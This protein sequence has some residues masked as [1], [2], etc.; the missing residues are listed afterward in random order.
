MWINSQLP[1]LIQEYCRRENAHI[2][3][4]GCG[5]GEYSAVFHEMGIKGSYLGIDIVRHQN[6]SGLKMANCLRVEHKVFDAE[7][8]GGIGREFDFICA[9]TSFEHFKDDEAVLK[10]AYRVLKNE[11]RMLV[12]VPSHYSILNY[13]KHGWRQYSK[14]DIIEVSARAGFRTEKD[15]EICGFA[16][17]LFHLTWYWIFKILK[18]CFKGIVVI[19]FGGKKEK[20]RRALPR[21]HYYLDG[22]MFLHLLTI[23]GKTLHKCILLLCS[24]VD[25]YL[26]FC[27]VGYFV[28]LKK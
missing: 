1:R 20:A 5:G 25:K 23:P 2:L 21:L 13:G 24:K 17:F 7:K 12:I 8:L 9:I 26:P 16:S 18:V 11:G 15:G 3:D 4:L 28:V 6:W 14:R 10:G 19:L 22:L 27:P